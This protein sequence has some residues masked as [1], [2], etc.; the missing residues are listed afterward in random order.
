MENAS[1][2]AI[3]IHNWLKRN[4]LGWKTKCWPSPE[5]KFNCAQATGLKSAKGESVFAVFTI[6]R[7]MGW[8]QLVDGSQA[9]ECGDKKEKRSLFPCFLEASQSARSPSAHSLFPR[10]R[11][12]SPSRPRCR[13]SWILGPCVRW[14]PLSLNQTT[15]RK[16]ERARG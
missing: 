9:S 12:P 7:S 2:E 16:R 15:G 3:M 6:T 10:Y 13:N 5:R 1:N 11:P 8:F 14:Q 4:E